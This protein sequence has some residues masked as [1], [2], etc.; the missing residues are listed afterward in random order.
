M[1]TGTLPLTL[2]S[3]SKQPECHD[4]AFL[5]LFPIHI[6][7]FDLFLQILFILL[8][9]FDIFFNLPN[10]H[11]KFIITNFSYVS[12]LCNAQHKL[13]VVFCVSDGGNSF[14][15]SHTVKDSEEVD[16]I[17]FCTLVEYTV[18]I[19]VIYLSIYI[20]VKLYTF[21][22]LHLSKTLSFRFTKKRK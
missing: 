20:L 9:F 17:N 5:F 3:V 15:T 13:C 11:L 6:T 1:L 2:M 4:S 21:T 7:S 12:R 18:D 16:A 19:S 14:V 10:H 8:S 22:P